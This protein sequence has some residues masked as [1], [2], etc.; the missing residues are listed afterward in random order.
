MVPDDEIRIAQIR[1]IQRFIFKTVFFRNPPMGHLHPMYR[2]RE[3]NDPVGVS[4]TFSLLDDPIKIPG[5]AQNKGETGDKPSDK[6]LPIFRTGLHTE[7]YGKEIYSNLGIIGRSGTE[8]NGKSTKYENRRYDNRR[9]NEPENR[10]NE[11]RKGLNKNP[12]KKIYRLHINDEETDNEG[13]TETLKNEER[14][15]ADQEDWQ[16]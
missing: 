8:K 10:A 13:D 9:E 6:T 4:G 11:E 15:I 3:E 5:Y 14:Q 7:L 12:M 1:I 16:Y 2:G